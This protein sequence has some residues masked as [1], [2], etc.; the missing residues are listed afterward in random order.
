M[1]NYTDFFFFL[2]CFLLYFVFLSV[3]K[4]NEKKND[5]NDVIFY[6]CLADYPC[7]QIRARK[8]TTI[9]PHNP[10]RMQK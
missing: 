2:L 3:N 6:V 1:M 9:K 4:N 10:I 5:A 8:P 7:I